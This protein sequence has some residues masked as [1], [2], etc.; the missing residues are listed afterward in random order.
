MA[1]ASKANTDSKERFTLFI[2]SSTIQKLD[3]ISRVKAFSSNEKV[4][5]TDVVSAALEEYIQKWEK[6]N[7]SISI[8]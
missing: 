8:K 7:G 5:R 3:H 1:K 6:K 2:L 4:T